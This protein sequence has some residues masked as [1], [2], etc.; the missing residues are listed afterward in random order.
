MEFIPTILSGGAGTRLWPV[1]R[2][3]FPKQFCDIFNSSLFQM[4]L[5]RLSKLGS[6]WVVTNEGLKVLTETALRNSAIPVE[7]ALFEPKANN[8]A[9]AIAFLCKVLQQQGKQKSVVGIFPSD[10]LVDNAKNF[11]AA[12]KLG[13]ECA[14]K[15]QVVTLGIKPTYPA[16]GYGYIEIT[17]DVFKTSGGLSAQPTKGFREKPNFDTAENFIAAGN[18]FW[19]AGMFIFEAATMIEHF[20]KWM[21]DL[22]AVID[23]LAPNFN[24]LKEVYARCPS[25]SIDYGI[26]EKIKEQVCIPCDLG[27]SDVGSWDEIAKLK[28]SAPKT[29]VDSYRNYVFS[30]SASIGDKVVGFIDVTDLI[31]IDT[32]DA[33]LITKRDSSQKV[34]TLLEIILKSGPGRAG[35]LAAEHPFEIRPW[36]RFEVL[37]DTDGFKSKIIQVNPGQQLSYQSHAKRAEHWV[38]VKG[39]PEVTLDDVVHQLKPGENIYIPQGAKHRIRNPDKKEIVEFVEVQVGTYFGED[40]IVRYQDDYKRV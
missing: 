4:T 8:T 33:L 29:E 25:Q 31:V 5:D 37:R 26:M 10:H 34:K 18:F 16:T 27:W 11:E 32:V 21:P 35:K 30:E 22:W 39:N 28:P 36:G 20:K 9:P 40:D 24:N 3:K 14:Q 38:I 23:T 19:N 12:V 1:S 2:T 13:I 7:Q 6:P 15:G 17:K